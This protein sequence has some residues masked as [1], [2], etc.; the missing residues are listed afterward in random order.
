MA[1]LV[2]ENLEKTFG[3]FTAVKNF[4]LHVKDGEFVSFLGPSG[5]GK[6]TTLA[7]I[8]GLDRA[9]GGS[10]R[11]GSR[12]CFDSAK[13]IH[14]PPEARGTGLVFQSYALWPHMTIAQ[15]VAFPLKLRKVGAAEQ[16]R[17]IEEVLD[18]VELGTFA[19]RYPHQLSGGQQQRAALARTL[20]YKPDILLLD[21]PLSNLD[22]KLR[23]R[24][25]VWL[26]ELSTKLRMTTIYV[27]HDQVEALA[28]SDRIV[29]MNGGHI[30]QIGTP[31]EIYEQPSD[32]FVAD[33][34]GT[35]NFIRGVAA[36]GRTGTQS[37]LLAD[38]QLMEMPEQVMSAVGQPLTLAL[39]PTQ[40][41][42]LHG[43][44]RPDGGTVLDANIVSQAYIG[45]RWQVSMDIGGNAVR[46][47]V[48]DKQADA[49]ARIWVP[50]TGGALFPTAPS[51]TAVRH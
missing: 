50:G 51:D 9:S 21:E 2:I 32:A 41:Q 14:L 45:G 19:D 6:S 11:I 47:D 28:L 39:R 25:R 44:V 26:A 3:S 40:M 42:F 5:C 13:G 48:D 34:I 17:R 31:Q 4:S 35:T 10:I 27:T 22:A 38:G 15:N 20:V 36:E 7:A 12:V 30:A 49:K 1:E 37:L 23:D 8:A 24:S 18:L 16:K 29:V 43:S 33:F 46:L